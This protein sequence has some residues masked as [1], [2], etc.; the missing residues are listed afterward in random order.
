MPK[1][2]NFVLMMTIGM[3]LYVLFHLWPQWYYLTITNTSIGIITLV[4]MWMVQCSDPGI[5]SRKELNTPILE[6]E[7]N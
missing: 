2:A 4:L 7:F 3:N 1:I 5:Q 6:Q